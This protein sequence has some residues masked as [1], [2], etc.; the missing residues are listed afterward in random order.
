VLDTIGE[1][2]RLGFWVEVV[3]LVVPDFNDSRADVVTLADVI[4]AV[5]PAIPWHLNAFQPRYKMTA[6]PAMDPAVLLSAAGTALS[7]G[8]D[9]VYVGNTALTGFEATRCPRCH[10]TLVERRNYQ[11]VRCAWQG[12]RCPTCDA[13]IPGL[14]RRPPLSEVSAS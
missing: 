13:E 8:L 7:R 5:S 2:V 4:R 10:E 14:W 3:T 1:A 6:R 11:T 9:F 12:P